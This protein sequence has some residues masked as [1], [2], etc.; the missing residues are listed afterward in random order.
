MKKQGE[1]ISIDLPKMILNFNQENRYKIYSNE[2]EFIV[3]TAQNAADAIELSK[4]IN[5]YRIEHILEELIYIID[6]DKLVKQ[7][8]NDS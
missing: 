3:I 1:F 2:I 5:P 7:N 6:K 8:P 4:I